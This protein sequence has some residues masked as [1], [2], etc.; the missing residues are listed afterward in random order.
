MKFYPTQPTEQAYSALEMSGEF[1]TY[2]GNDTQGICA[3]DGLHHNVNLHIY[4]QVDPPRLH[5]YEKYLYLYNQDY[6]DFYFQTFLV[7]E[8]IVTLEMPGV[9]KLNWKVIN[10]LKAMVYLPYIW[11]KF[12]V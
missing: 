7:D 8:L 10:T 9:L 12:H 1:G 3:N 2:E 11:K 5:I 6:L 4:V